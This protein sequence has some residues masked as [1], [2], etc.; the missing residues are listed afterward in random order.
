MPGPYSKEN[1]AFHNYK[2]KL[3]NAVMKSI[4]F[5]QIITT[6]AAG[7]IV[8]QL[9]LVVHLVTRIVLYWLRAHQCNARVV[10][11]PRAP[12]DFIWNSRSSRRHTSQRS[13]STE[14]RNTK[15]SSAFACVIK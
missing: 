7:K 9:Q 13:A 14:L 8:G 2:Y 12:P 3:I 1:T 11:R 15:Y 6:H 5:I 10:Q 4:L